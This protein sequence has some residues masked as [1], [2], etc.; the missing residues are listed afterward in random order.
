[1]SE[2]ASRPNILRMNRHDRTPTRLARPILSPVQLR[3]HDD[4]RASREAFAQQLE[5]TGYEIGRRFAERRVWA[6]LSPIEAEGVGVVIPVILRV[7]LLRRLTR[8]RERLMESLDVMKWLCREF[9]TEAFRKPV[10]KL[11]TNNRGVFVLQDFSFRLTRFISA[12][13]AEDGKALV[14]K[15]MLLPCGLLRGALAAFGIDAAVN[16]DITSLPRATFHIKLLE[17]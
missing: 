13:P 6:P 2:L 4:T 15:Y 17:G 5:S 9:W 14:L 3:N 16:L 12:G 10:D 8:D 11:Q 1:M 7:A